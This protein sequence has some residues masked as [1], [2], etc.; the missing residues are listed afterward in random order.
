MT[1]LGIFSDKFFCT[2]LQVGTAKLCMI[3]GSF[4]MLIVLQTVWPV[5]FQG[6]KMATGHHVLR[7]TTTPKHDFFFHDV[8]IDNEIQ[9]YKI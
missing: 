4:N 7:K 1:R 3:L 2:A 8:L 6:W 9:R 5:C